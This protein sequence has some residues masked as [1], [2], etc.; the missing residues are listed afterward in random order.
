MGA[1]V[2]HACNKEGPDRY[3][4]IIL[5]SY[6]YYLTR[7]KK[8]GHKITLSKWKIYVSQRDLVLNWA[9]QS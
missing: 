2:S 4:G 6:V 1:R 5:I 8:E 3:W 7:G 9:I